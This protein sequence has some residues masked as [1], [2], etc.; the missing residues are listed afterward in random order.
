M[1]PT[2]AWLHRTEVETLRKSW[3]E[4]HLINSIV[5]II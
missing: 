5:K 2:A 3:N 4:T 1:Y